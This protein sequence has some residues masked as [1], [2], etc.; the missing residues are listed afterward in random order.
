M[1]TKLGMGD[2]RDEIA[3]AVVEVTEENP[4]I[5]TV[6]AISTIPCIMCGY[7]YRKSAK[8]YWGSFWESLTRTQKLL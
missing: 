4:E 2:T 1:D 7:S 6:V 3:A 5:A 8:E